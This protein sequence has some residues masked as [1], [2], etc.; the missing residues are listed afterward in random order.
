MPIKLLPGELQYNRLIPDKSAQRFVSIQ[1]T[2]E[3]N[4]VG[5]ECFASHQTLLSD[6]LEV[7]LEGSAILFQPYIYGFQPFSGTRQAQQG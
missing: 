5:I 7:L 3:E 4:H 2:D 6:L 1:V